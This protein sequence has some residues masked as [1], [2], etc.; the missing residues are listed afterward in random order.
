METD[1]DAD[2]ATKNADNREASAK[3]KKKE[4]EKA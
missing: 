1:E 2:N 3:D 4:K